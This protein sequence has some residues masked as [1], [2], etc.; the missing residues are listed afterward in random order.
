MSNSLSHETPLTQARSHCKC[1]SVEGMKKSSPSE[2]IAKT[3]IFFYVVL[4]KYTPREVT[5]E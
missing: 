4:R 2:K 1:I 5:A 3:C